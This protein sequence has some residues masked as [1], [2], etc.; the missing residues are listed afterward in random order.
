MKLSQWAGARLYAWLELCLLRRAPQDDAASPAALWLALLLYTVTDVVIAAAS[1]SL[2]VALAM[3][4]VDVAVLAA[5]SWA[6][7]RLTG[8]PARLLQTLT[9][10]AGSGVILGVL[11]LPLVQQAAAAQRN[12]APAA[13]LAMLWLVLVV[14]SVVVRA[15]IFRHALS[16]GFSVGMLVAVLHAVLLFGLVEYLFPRVT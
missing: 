7:L 15:H 2:R 14:W 12:D 9:A 11:A 13:G 4:A 6:L 10:L 8:R 5:F 16:A 1:S 3:T